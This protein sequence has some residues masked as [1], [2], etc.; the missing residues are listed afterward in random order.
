MVREIRRPVALG[1][2]SDTRDSVASIPDVAAR[3]CL[4]PHAQ[5]HRPAWPGDPV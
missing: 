5:C 1:E 2:G 4:S 3:R